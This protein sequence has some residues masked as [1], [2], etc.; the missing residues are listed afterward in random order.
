M[1]VKLGIGSFLE[2]VYGQFQLKDIRANG[3]GAHVFYGNYVYEDGNA[4]ALTF[5]HCYSSTNKQTNT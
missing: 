1:Q 5:D 4:C 3:F 2:D